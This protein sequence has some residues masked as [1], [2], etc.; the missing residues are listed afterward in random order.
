[1]LAVDRATGK[2]RVWA[3][4]DTGGC[5]PAA[6]DG[7]VHI[8]TA[9]GEVLA[10][11]AGTGRVRWSLGT[12]GPPVGRPAVSGGVVYAGSRDRCLYA[13]KAASGRVLWRLPTGG[14]V[15]GGATVRGDSVYLGS[16][17]GRLYRVA[18]ATGSVGWRFDAGGW[19]NRC[20]PAAGDGLVYAGTAGGHLHAVDMRTGQGIAAPPPELDVR[21]EL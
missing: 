4:G 6:A 12:G 15:T 9:A 5:D 3:V 20:A 13:I 16:R 19:I 2:A 1:M 10:L 8:G 7:T 21:L 11:D 14:P 18:R 17:D